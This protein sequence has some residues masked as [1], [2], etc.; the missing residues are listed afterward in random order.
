MHLMTAISKHRTGPFCTNL[1][2]TSASALDQQDPDCRLDDDAAPA[3]T[4]EN[5]PLFAF[6]I[7]DTAKFC[8]L[9]CMSPSRS[10]TWR[11]EMQR[12]RALPCSVVGAA[13]CSTAAAAAGD[14]LFAK[15]GLLSENTAAGVH[16]HC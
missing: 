9:L 8:P 5:M 1:W 7:E 6:F 15:E 3:C 12:E 16:E 2:R 14:D 13:P 4:C 11:L 10:Y